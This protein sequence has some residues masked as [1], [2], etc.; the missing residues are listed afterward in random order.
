LHHPQV[1]VVIPGTST[2]KNLEDNIRAL[3]AQALTRE[4]LE[5]IALFTKKSSYKKERIEA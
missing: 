3:E 4:E 5:K 2:V 1:S